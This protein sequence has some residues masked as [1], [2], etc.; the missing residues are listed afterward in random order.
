MQTLFDRNKTGLTHAVTQAITVWLNKRGFKPI[1]TEVPVADGW[2]A[3]LASAIIPT[4]TE[5][6]ELKFVPRCP[7]YQELELRA[8]WRTKTD[9]LR[10]LMTVLVEIKTSRGDFKNDTKWQ[11]EVPSDLA[12][13]AVP[14]GMITPSEWPEGYGILEYYEARGVVL[15]QR[16]PII[17]QVAPEV[18]RDILYEIAM[19]RDHDTRYERIRKIN[20]E[21]RIQRN[22]DVSRTRINDAVRL[23]LAV[24]KGELYRKEFEGSLDELLERL[25]FSHLPIDVRERLQD[26]WKTIR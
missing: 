14:A 17:R 2:V 25:N 13:L 23:V 5:L 21:I 3:D 15:C 16:V 7:G 22:G 6:Q 1:E 11:R 9:S 12:Y 18:Q 4:R 24:A 19:R 26:I 20:K 8:E 10:R